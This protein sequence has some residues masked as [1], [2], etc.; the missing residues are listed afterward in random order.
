MDYANLYLVVALSGAI[1]S[2]MVTFHP[3]NKA[4]KMPL[5]SYAIWLLL[6][7]ILFPLTI[8]YILSETANNKI[9]IETI[10]KANKRD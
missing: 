8:R 1:V 7:T 2:T 9:I 3:V 5:Y 6:A 10:E 4:L